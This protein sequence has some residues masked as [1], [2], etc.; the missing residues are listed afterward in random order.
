MADLTVARISACHK[1]FAIGG[2]DLFGHVNYVEARGPVFLVHGISS[3]IQGDCHLPR[4]K[5]LL[6]GI[7]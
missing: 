4:T 7:Y 6:I 1:A 5:E 3:S 2:L